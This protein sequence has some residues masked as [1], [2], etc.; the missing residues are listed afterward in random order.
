MNKKIKRILIIFLL[1]MVLIYTKSI[2]NDYDAN[3]GGDTGNFYNMRP[4][5]YIV[6]VNFNNSLYWSNPSCGEFKYYCVEFAQDL[7]VIKSNGVSYFVEHVIDL[8]GKKATMDGNEYE[9]AEI[10]R[11]AYILSKNEGYQDGTMWVDEW[12]YYFHNGSDGNRDYSSAAD[13]NGASFTTTQKL[14]WLYVN[15]FANKMG[16]ELDG[17]ANARNEGFNGTAPDSKSDQ[18]GMYWNNLNGERE[19]VESHQDDYLDKTEGKIN[20]DNAKIFTSTYSGDSTEYIE[21]G[22]ITAEFASRDGHLSHSTEIKDQN[23]NMIY[24][25]SYYSYENGEKIFVDQSQL[26]SG[27]EFYLRFEPTQ[28]VKEMTKLKIKITPDVQNVKTARIIVIN[29]P[30]HQRLFFVKSGEENYQSSA[31]KEIPVSITGSLEIKKADTQSGNGIPNVKMQIKRNSNNKWVIGNLKGEVSYIN[32]NDSVPFGWYKV[33]T[34]ESD[35]KISIK[36]LYAGDYTITEVENTNSAYVTNPNI[37]VSVKVEPVKTTYTTI[38]NQRIIDLKILKQDTD[39]NKVLA[40]VKFKIKRSSDG[41]FIKKSGI[42]NITYVEENDATEF[43]TDSNG[44]ILIEGITAGEYV[45]IEIENP[46]KGYEK[47]PNTSILLDVNGSGDL[48]RELVIKNINNKRKYVDISGYVWEDKG[49]GK[50]NLRNDLYKNDDSDAKDQGVNGIKV[51]LKEYKSKDLDGKLVGTEISST[52]TA[53]SGKYSEIDGGEFIFSDVEI[54]KLNNYYVEYEYNGLKYQSATSNLNQ[55]NGSKAVDQVERNLLDEKFAEID[56]TGSNTVSVKDKNKEEVLKV[57][58]NQTEEHTAKPNIVDNEITKLHANTKDA[59][60]TFTYDYNTGLSEIRYINLGI[61]EKEQA[62]LALAQDLYNVNVGVNG[63]WHIYN[64]QSRID[65][66]TNKFKT[67][68]DTTEDQWDAWNVGVKFKNSNTGTYKRAIYKSDVN[69]ET[70][71]KNKELQVYLTYKVG[72]KNESTFLTR[73]NKVVEYYDNRYDLVEVGTEIDNENNITKRLNYNINKDYNDKYSKVTIETNTEVKPTEETYIY[74]Q[75]KLSR[76]AILNILNSNIERDALLYSIAE[77]DSYTVFKDENGSTV[78]AIDNDSVPGNIEIGNINTYED[79]NDSAPPIK[80]ELKNDRSIEGT[81]FLDE[82]SN[83]LKTGQVRQ[84]DGEYT[85]DDKT[86]I[87]GVKVS[88]H[89][90]LEDGSIDNNVTQVY[91]G[92]EWIE[93]ST[94]TNDDGDFKI[95]GYIPGQYVVVYTWGDKE[96]QVQYYKGTIYDINRD[97]NNKEWYKENVE[98]RKTDAIDN[99]E[100]RKLID[101]QVSKFTNHNV[102]EEISKAYDNG[103]TGNI[104]N[105]INSL[106]P[107]IQI[108]VEYDTTITDGIEDKVEF[109]IR[110]VDFGLVRRARQKLNLEKRVSGFKVTLSNGQVLADAKIVEDANGKRHLEGTTNH[111]TIGNPTNNFRGYVKLEIDNEIIEG[112]T[113]NVEYEIKAVNQSEIEYVSE[114]Y[115]KYGKLGTNE[116]KVTLTP[117]EIVDYLDKNLALDENLNEDWEQITNI[118]LKELKAIGVED[119]NQKKIVSTKNLSIERLL[120]GESKSVYLYAAKLL[121]STEDITFD[122]DA[123]VVTIKYLNKN[124]IQQNEP[125]M[126]PIEYPEK[127]STSEEIQIVPSTGA[128]MNYTVPIIVGIVSL[129]ILG[130][131]VFVIKKKIIEK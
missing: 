10:G 122:N 15:D 90:V 24:N 74:I 2:A 130:I 3:S 49:N 82:T 84:G 77:I 1:F 115:Y 85:S 76:N 131:G 58:Y 13:K 39:T 83:E 59:N 62:D 79:D 71:D 51:L 123:E 53:E 48:K 29:N 11:I 70:E 42:E 89:K 4:G 67:S 16:I 120:P 86:K 106:T 23:D 26:K 45:A 36:G 8:V 112:A 104:I 102:K 9:G 40:N 111:M 114:D 52:T 28:Q 31:E 93:A 119:L 94:L 61:Y 56:S 30:T 32:E 97:Q 12:E 27:K 117:Y 95:S 63:Y 108:G 17:G 124:L 78:A 20:N 100:E 113:L 109:I 18:L 68:Q 129:V 98:V 121:T 103:Y 25:V 110:N 107:T 41:K 81:V 80:L 46:N 101:E 54:T 5:D 21:Y 87:S 22:P 88:L 128:N 105:K 35:G 6:N 50:D 92:T 55:D 116:Q 33:F 118:K 64:Y 14:M 127:V 65:K 57:D 126:V 47:N 73:A 69:Y 96:Y 37:T 75:Y 72:I 38:N 34:T 19:N 43:Y 66:T 91:N 60:Y 125:S 99:Y 7:N 44:Q